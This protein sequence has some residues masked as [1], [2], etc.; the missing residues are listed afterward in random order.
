MSETYNLQVAGIERDLRIVPISP[1]LSIASFVMLGDTELVEKCADALC[2]KIKGFKP[3]YI[4]CPEA[5]AIPLTHAVAVRLGI[6][7]IVIRK[8]VKGYMSN[9]IIYDVHSIT[10]NYRQQLVLD[11]ADAIRLN[12]KKIIVVD[13][14]VSTGGSLKA[15][16]ECLAGTNCTVLAE[17]CVLLEDAGYSDPKLIYLETLPVFKK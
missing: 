10:S 5:K 8:T 15:V 14:V 17:A 4:V 1:T 3:D 12:G 9:P 16:R 7:Y 13:D 11:G 6:N 2:R